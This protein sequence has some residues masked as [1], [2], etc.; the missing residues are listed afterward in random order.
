MDNE[1][2][3]T[4]KFDFLRR[5]R[6]TFATLQG[7]QDAEYKRHRRDAECDARCDAL[8]A[9]HLV[10]PVGDFSLSKLS[11]VYATQSEQKRLRSLICGFDVCTLDGDVFVD[12]AKSADAS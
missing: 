9:S 5:V 4:Q 11:A 12:L 10:F 2:F 1:C 8:F 6:H 3:P 7:L